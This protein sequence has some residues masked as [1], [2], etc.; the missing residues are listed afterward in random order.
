MKIKFFDLNSNVIFIL[1]YFILLISEF[2]SVSVLL[3]FYFY[4]V[5]FRLFC[6]NLINIYFVFII[7][8]YFIITFVLFLF[9]VKMSSSFLSNIIDFPM[10]MLGHQKCSKTIILFGSFVRNLSEIK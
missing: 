5:S 7:I 3:S 6:L 4:S 10:K 1:L 9:Y 2:Y 8:I